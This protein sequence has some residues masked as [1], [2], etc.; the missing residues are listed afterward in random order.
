[1]QY[2][3]YESNYDYVNSTA[4]SI[5]AACMYDNAML[6][7]VMYDITRTKQSDLST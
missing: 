2:R 1:M 7:R 5:L 4:E 6:A 3:P